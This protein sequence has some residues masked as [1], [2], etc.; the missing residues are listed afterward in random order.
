[1][2]IITHPNDIL[3]KKAVKVTDADFNSK[4]FK[5]FIDE[6]SGAMLEKDGLGLAA[7]QVGVSKRLFIANTK[8]GPI[9]MI[10]PKIIKKSWRK[11]TDE[12]GCLSLPGVYGD[13]A[14]YKT[15]KVKAQNHQGREVVLEAKGLFARVIQHEMDHLDG[16]LFIDRAKKTRDMRKAE[17]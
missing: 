3:R 16:V 4:E 11:E 14:R 10:N 15:L 2:Q 6:M 9:A 13:V 7:P 8:Q 1:M 5:K 12:E 17:L